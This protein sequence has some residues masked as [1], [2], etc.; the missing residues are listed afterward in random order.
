MPHLDGFAPLDRLKVMTDGGTYLPVIVLTADFT[1][2]AKQRALSLGAND[3][4]TKPFDAT[5]VLLRIHNM[6][7]TRFLHLQ[8]REQNLA[9][10]DRVRERTRDLYV[11]HVQ[12]LRRLAKAAEYRDDVTGKHTER[13]GELARRLAAG[14]GW[15]EGEIE[16][17]GMAAP[18]T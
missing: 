7:E 11:A 17:I 3:F 12:T 8:L 18:T 14:L 4:L 9:L 13:V 2:E 16:L 10:E 5:E 1:R 6:L 15:P